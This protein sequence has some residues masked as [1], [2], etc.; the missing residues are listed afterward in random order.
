MLL[1]SAFWCAISSKVAVFLRRSVSD[2]WPEKTSSPRF[3]KVI[4][5]N[6]RERPGQGIQEQLAWVGRTNC[7]WYGARD[8]FTYPIPPIPVIEI[9]VLPPFWHFT[10]ICFKSFNSN[11]RPVILLRWFKPS[12]SKNLFSGGWKQFNAIGG[13]TQGFFSTESES[14]IKP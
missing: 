12:P 14:V 3:L 9:A 5:R 10:K 7:S 6:Y 1:L 13:G 11:S 8:W 2:H 4:M